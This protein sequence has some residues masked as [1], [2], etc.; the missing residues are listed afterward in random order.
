MSPPPSFDRYHRQ[1]LLPGIGEEGQRRLRESH[2]LIVG[3]GALGTYIA[4][5]LTRAGV[6]TLTIVDRDVVELTNLQRQV[7]FD[8]HDAQVGVPKAV[9]ARDK[10]LRINKQVDIR[11][12]VEDFNP[13]NAERILGDSGLILD[14]L[15]NFETRYLLNDLAVKHGRPYIYGGAVGTTGMTMAVIPGEPG[16]PGGTPCLRCVF[17]EAP[18]PG[19]SATCDTAGVWGPV[20]AMIAA[21]QASQALKLMT[22]N[23]EQLDRK[24]VSIDVWGND[25]R[26]FE[27]SAGRRKD[28][29]CCGER[30]FEYL[31]GGR[32]SDVVSLCG[33][34][35]VQVLP[36]SG[37]DEAEQV[38]IDLVALANRLGPHGEFSGTENLLRGTLRD[39]AQ[40]VAENEVE[41]TVFADGRAII[42]GTAEVEVAKS[43]YAKYVG[44]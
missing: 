15:D 22:G 9:A 44:G 38:M 8:E 33:R 17:P 41:L 43:I 18:P 24:L 1:M 7:L 34:N 37:G 35:A 5:F 31:E 19:S 40:F 27:V 6:G 42:K 23:I 39:G 2:A 20:V 29:I 14:G 4:D 36:N 3:C 30:K 11:A 26:G 10:L 21:R 32:G 28:C 13:R 16:E 12:F 25:C